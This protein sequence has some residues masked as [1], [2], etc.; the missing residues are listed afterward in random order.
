MEAL[1]HS[2]STAGDCG[3]W[4]Q[5]YGETGHKL[6]QRNAAVVVL[7][8]HPSSAYIKIHF[9]LHGTINIWIFYSSDRYKNI[10]DIIHVGWS[11]SFYLYLLSHTVHILFASLAH[12]F[13]N[14]SWH[15]I[16]SSSLKCT[17]KISYSRTL[18]KYLKKL[19]HICILC[20]RWVLVLENETLGCISGSFGGFSLLRGRSNHRLQH[21]GDTQHHISDFFV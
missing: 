10:H 17:W 4:I 18:G 5:L 14:A 2:I 19:H 21:A 8:S 11:I 9:D 7:L 3:R 20:C 6:R 12:T 1:A 15:W 16:T 13:Y